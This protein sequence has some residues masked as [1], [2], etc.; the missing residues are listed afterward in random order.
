[1]KERNKRK[2]PAYFPGGKQA[3]AL[4]ITYYE[5]TTRHKEKTCSRQNPGQLG[6]AA[7]ATKKALFVYGMGNGR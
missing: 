7:G 2:T 5:K 4:I 1:M 6:Y 3:G